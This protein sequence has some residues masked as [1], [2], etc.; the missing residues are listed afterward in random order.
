MKSE[1][2][3][4]LLILWLID[5]YIK[6]FFS[7]FIWQ[8]SGD[9]DACIVILGIRVNCAKNFL[10]SCISRYLQRAAR[11][12]RAWKSTFN[13]TNNAILTRNK[14]TFH[15]PRAAKISKRQRLLRNN[16]ENVG[17]HVKVS[18]KGGEGWSQGDEKKE[19]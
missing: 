14:S 12:H 8:R 6:K 1:R 16:A 2:H 3:R 18:V 11:S 15:F 4:L 9:L 19:E 13:V 7:I 17:G 10:L 5:C